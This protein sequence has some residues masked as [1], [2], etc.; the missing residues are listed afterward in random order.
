MRR[1]KQ[2]RISGAPPRP[3]LWSGRCGRNIERMVVDYGEPF[4]WGIHTFKLTPSPQWVSTRCSRVLA[5]ATG[6]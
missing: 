2:Q 6:F 4:M 3:R 1:T 5:L